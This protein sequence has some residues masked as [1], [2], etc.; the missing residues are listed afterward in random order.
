MAILKKVLLVCLVCLLGFSLQPAAAKSLPQDNPQKLTEPEISANVDGKEK[1]ENYYRFTAGPGKLTM[2]V[3]MQTN[4][5]TMIDF[6]FHIYDAK[7]KKLTG[8]FDVLGNS[9]T[10]RTVKEIRLKRRQTL[11]LKIVTKPSWGSGSYRVLMEGP[12][13]LSRE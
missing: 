6:D 8:F 9:A 13:K 5:G 11:N 12:L 10:K 7:W 3:D 2:T 4:S 1:V